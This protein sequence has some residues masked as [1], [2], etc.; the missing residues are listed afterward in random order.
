MPGLA[1]RASLRSAGRGPPS[2]REESKII[3]CRGIAFDLFH[4]LTGLETESATLQPTC[5]LLGVSRQVWNETLLE[6]SRWRLC[7]AERDPLAII[8]TLA[9][10][11][12]PRIPERRIAEAAR[13][14]SDRFRRS[15]LRIDHDIIRTLERLRSAG[16]K[17]GLISNADAAEIA[18]WSESPLARCFDT[19]LFSCEVGHVK[20][21]AEIYLEFLERL[22]LAAGECLFIGDGGSSELQGA[23]AVGMRPVLMSGTIATLWPDALAQRRSIADHE[24]TAIP[25]ILD[26]LDLPRGSHVRSC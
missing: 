2:K 11:I 20:P 6:K 19:A 8:R 21:E 10:S 22:D 16:L 24:I 25:E 17:L 7:G 4:T 13:V 26:L 1:R 18:A 12:D 5:E 14:R 23:K 15:L 9:H 3:T